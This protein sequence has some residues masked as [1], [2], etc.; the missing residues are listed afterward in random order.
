MTKCPYLHGF[1][2]FLWMTQFTLLGTE[3]SQNGAGHED[4]YAKIATFP[5]VTR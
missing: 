4:E 1:E 3:E 5:L 2:L